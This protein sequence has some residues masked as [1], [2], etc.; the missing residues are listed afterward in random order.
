MIRG[1][2]RPLKRSLNI[3]LLFNGGTC[4]IRGD[5][6]SRVSGITTFEKAVANAVLNNKDL[7]K[8]AF[9]GGCIFYTVGKFAKK[10]FPDLNGFSKFA[11]QVITATVFTSAF[12]FQTVLIIGVAQMLFLKI[13]SKIGYFDVKRGVVSPPFL[14]NLNENAKYDL[15]P[16]GGNERRETQV[17]SALNRAQYSNCLMI[18]NTGAGKT[19]VVRAIAKKLAENKIPKTSFFYGKTIY[20]LDVL[21]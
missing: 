11:A 18:A 16:C 21:N 9:A 17:E 7:V 13:A 5:Q 4:I 20:S 19:S 8:V 10:V 15:L 2:H 12:Q 3:G 14:H 6:E 1:L